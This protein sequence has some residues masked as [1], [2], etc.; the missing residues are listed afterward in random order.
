VNAIEAMRKWTS[1]LESDKRCDDC[2]VAEGELHRLGY[3]LERCPVCGEQAIA[4]EAHCWTP[5]GRPKRSFLARRVPFIA[6]ANFCRRCLTP[7]P[8]MFVVSNEEWQTNVPA[9]LQHE[10]LCRR[11]Y[12]LIAGWTKAAREPAAAADANDSV[13][14]SNEADAA[15]PQA[16][17]NGRPET[18]TTSHPDRR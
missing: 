2:G 13:E 9:D 14:A 11:C 1:E 5:T 18:E 15:W 4:C 17:Q 10:M 12:D 16:P 3:E 6:T 7:W 8:E